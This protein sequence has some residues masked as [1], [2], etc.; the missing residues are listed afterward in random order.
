MNLMLIPSAIEYCHGTDDA[1]T[2]LPYEYTKTLAQ[3]STTVEFTNMRDHVPCM[4]KIKST[5]G[6]PGFN[7]FT[8]TMQGNLILNWAEY[9]LTHIEV[10]I[11]ELATEWPALYEYFEEVS[12]LAD[13]SCSQ[14]DLFPM[15]TEDGQ[16]IQALS[17]IS[18]LNE[19]R[20]ENE[21]Y[22]VR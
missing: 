12:C 7:L 19:K 20:R 13:N 22:N 18:A 8:D 10:Y 21:I 14:G 16:E 6:A 1:G 15:V 17:I 3:N 11:D 4:T 2:E 9:D 5:D